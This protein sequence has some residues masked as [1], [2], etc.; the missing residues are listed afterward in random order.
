MSAIRK[1]LVVNRNAAVTVQT[2][3]R[4]VMNNTGGFVY[5][6]DDRSRL[7]RFLILGT[8]GGTFY[9]G[10]S[11]LTK[12]NLTFVDDLIK[13][14]PGMVVRVTSDISKSGRAYRNTPAIYVAARFICVCAPEFKGLAKVLIS[15]V[16]RTST[17]I[18]ELCGFIDQVG[19]WGQAKMDAVRR[20]YQ[21]K[22][23]SQLAY[24][25][26]KYRGG[27]YGWSHRDVLRTVHPKGLDSRVVNFA[28]GKR[29]ESSL[30]LPTGDLIDG[31]NLIQ[32]AKNAKTVV[33]VLAEYPKLPWEAIPTE[34]L[35]D[36]A[37]WR[38]LFD[39][40]Q[41]DGVNLIRNISRLD[42]IGA[43]KDLK[44][45][46][47]VGKTL[48]EGVRGSHPIQYLNAMAMNG[49]ISSEA[50]GRYGYDR[51][52][53]LTRNRVASP[54][55]KGLEDGFYASFKNVPESDESVLLAVD[56]SS[57]MSWAAPAGLKNLSCAQASG[58]LAMVIARRN[59]A[60]EI[61][62]F[63]G[64]FIDLGVTANDS[65]AEAMRKVQCNNFGCTNTSLPMRWAAKNRVKIDKFVVITDNEVNTGRHPVR[66]LR[67]YR[68]MVNPSAKLIVVGMVA[69]RFTIAD[70]EDPGML[71]VVGFDAALPDLI[72]NF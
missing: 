23:P 40:G 57:S 10:E 44:F 50:V 15:E 51:R 33:R 55:A 13:R 61:R 3:P 64:N 46:A 34:F 7:E 56:V 41:L 5:S 1:G 69:T 29:I 47:M 37:V 49:I 30:S 2:L 39:N 59:P 42:D 24:Q 16:C 22:N 63:A 66:A 71:D 60:H 65:L 31:F 70:P 67:D 36:V 72:R 48:A 9:V 62:G 18:F 25:V 26:V 58:A 28:L 17:H 54:V 27:R 45:A 6:V 52:S 53:I 35:C 8:D 43:F 14:D 4:Q 20:W 38:Q 11:D 19:G 68:S 12:Q 21:A 32:A